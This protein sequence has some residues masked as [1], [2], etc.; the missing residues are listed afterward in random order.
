MISPADELQRVVVVGGSVAGARTCQALREAGFAGELV[1]IEPQL[2]DAYDRPPLSKAYLK[3][4]TTRDGIR[5]IPGGWASV[6]AQVVPLAAVALNAKAQSVTVADG[7]EVGYDGLVIAT[8]LS[9]KALT[10]TDGH[11]IGHVIGNIADADNLRHEL[12]SGGHVVVVGSG[13]V[14]AEAASVARELGLE[15]TVVHRRTHLLEGALGAAVGARISQMHTESGIELRGNSRISSIVRGARGAQLILD[16]GYELHADILIAGLGSSP[17]T[18]W[19][20][21]S[22]VRLDDGVLTDARCRVVG[23]PRVYALGDVARF[24][25][26]NSA[27]PRRACHWTN[28]ADQAT[29]VAHNLLS[30]KDPKG[31]REAPYFWTDQLGQKIQVVGHPDPKAH[32]DLLTLPGAVERHVAIYTHGDDNDCGAVATF[33]WPRGMV[34]ARRLMPL[35]PSTE[36]MIVTLEDLAAGTRAAA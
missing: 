36:E 30:P 6:G 1:V 31:Y 11:A 19:L 12:A 34:A 28:A 25:D 35:D 15:V 3:G 20:T 33:G 8:G 17:N 5:L 10:D 23:A 9:P 26:V 2:G 32:V 22:G 7:S 4:Q 16:S 24:Y 21:G 27:Q 14:A 29:V 13:Y 18:E